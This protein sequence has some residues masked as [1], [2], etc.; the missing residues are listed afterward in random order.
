M[1]MPGAIII[2]LFTMSPCYG[3]AWTMEKGKFYD[4]FAV[5]Y[6]FTDKNFDKNGHKEDS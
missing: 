2:L 1:T 4:R 5:N 3:G 6:Y